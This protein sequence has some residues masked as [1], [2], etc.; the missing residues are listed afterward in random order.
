LPD[1]VLHL[2]TLKNQE[3]RLKEQNEKNTVVLNNSI[4]QQDLKS[5]IE[6]KIPTPESQFVDVSD[7]KNIILEYNGYSYERPIDYPNGK[8]DPAFFEKKKKVFIEEILR[9]ERLQNLQASDL[10][11]QKQVTDSM[12]APKPSIDNYSQS[13]TQKSLQE[14]RNKALFGS[15]MANLLPGP[16][17]PEPVKRPGT[18]RGDNQIA[19]P[20]DLLKQQG[21]SHVRY[22][23]TKPVPGNQLVKGDVMIAASK[24]TTEEGRKEA[25]DL[26]NNPRPATSQPVAKVQEGL[27][28]TTGSSK[29]NP[30]LRG[31]LK[32][33]D[34]EDDVGGF[35]QI[36]TYNAST[37]S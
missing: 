19:S 32:D 37:S 3:Q 11:S 18:K 10:L 8:E 16:A 4:H 14:E 33:L 34:D 1:T 6:N 20:E 24:L 27:N 30:F 21:S 7:E 31:T 25:L 35:T 26:K 9:D 36:P 17:E 23:E 15:E 5:F 28:L 12:M 22:E 29:T 13:K 2:L